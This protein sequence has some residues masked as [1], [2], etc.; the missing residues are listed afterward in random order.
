MTKM[1]K[2]NAFEDDFEYKVKD[3]I[4]IDL[5]GDTAIDIEV[6]AV[7]EPG[8]EVAA[9]ETAGAEPALY[10][11][12]QDIRKGKLIKASEEIELGRKIHL[13]DSQALSKLVVSNLRLVVSI[14][15]KY[16]NQGLDLEDLIQEGNLGLIHAA[17]K[18]DPSMGTRFSTYATWWIRQSVMR[19]IANKGRTIRIP[20]HVR[21]QLSKLKKAAREFN[22]QNDRMPSVEELVALTE[23]SAEEVSK[24]LLCT[25]MILS[26]D[27]P[28]PGSDNMP[29]G[30]FVEDTFSRL[31][32]Q[33][34]EQA[35]LRRCIEKLTRYLTPQE[36][37]AIEY[38][39]GLEG[40]GMYDPQ[41]VADKL[42][43][44][45]LE[46]RRIQKRSLKK[47]RRQLH[48]RTIADFISG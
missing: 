18:Y 27:E 39:Y 26:L 34:A 12:L 31:P 1:Q 43:V 44:D 28:T 42:N 10:L 40:D 9:G 30:A 6:D 22:Q 11:Y 7:A 37:E 5:V 20:V 33:I 4:V 2:L 23:F 15:K 16:S 35:I 8:A 36:K 47:M 48:H 45:I 46:L 17:K 25:N 19:A 38:L 13:G 3:D 32:E 24:L 14:A 29:L 21:G 41:M